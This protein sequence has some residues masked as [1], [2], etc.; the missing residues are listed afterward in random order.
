MEAPVPG[1]GYVGIEVPNPA[2]ARVGLRDVM[3]SSSYQ[4]IESP[5]AIALGMSVDGKPIAADL[6]QM[7]HLLVAGTTGSGKS[8]ASTRSSTAS[9][10]ITRPK[11]SDSLWLTPSAWN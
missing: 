8:S 10:S 1:K 2:S 9:W 7:P 11:P 6:T 4:K 5:L 3:D